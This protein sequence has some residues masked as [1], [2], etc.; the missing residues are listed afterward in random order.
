MKK[1]NVF[2]ILTS[3]IL[4]IFTGSLIRNVEN[5]DNIHGN[6][7]RAVKKQVKATKKEVKSLE[8]EKEKLDEELQELS[9]ENEGTS[10][11]K[12][13]I[14]LKKELSYTEVSG[15]GLIISIDA[16]DDKTGNI[17]NAIDYNKVLLNTVNEL[18]SS[19]AKYIEINEQRVNQYSEIILAGNH[20]KV[21]GTSIAQ[22]YLIRAIGDEDKLSKY[23]EGG[24]NYLEEV[25]LSLPVKVEYKLKNKINLK[26]INIPDNLKYLDGE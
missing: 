19:G 21:N 26:Q 5:T 16:V 17:A 25:S 24:S 11:Y 2:I 1:I 13:I 23:M 22:P 7:G 20:I 8:K 3:L 14:S 9:K 15:P 12:K 6:T 4:G 10:G 18:K